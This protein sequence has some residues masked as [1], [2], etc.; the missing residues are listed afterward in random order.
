MAIK[1]NES[2]IL[3]FPRE[4]VYDVVKD[5]KSYPEFLPWCVGAHILEE[6]QDGMVADLEIGYKAF[7]ETYRSKVTYRPYD[8][9]ETQCEKG[10]LERLHNSWLFEE[11]DATHTHVHFFIDFAFKSMLFQSAME[12]VFTASMKKIM[13]AFEDRMRQLHK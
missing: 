8:K 2:R 5:V 10:P 7:R 4:F 13:V 9:I 1:I 3:P 6:N 11:V 12:A